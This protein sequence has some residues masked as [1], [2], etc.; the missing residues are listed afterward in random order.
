[1]DDLLHLL[2]SFIAS[3]P[4]LGIWRRYPDISEAEDDHTDSWACE[5]VSAEFA[6]FARDLG[7]DAAV[8]HGVD[9]EAPLAF[10]HA[11]VRLTRDGDVTDVDWTA[12]QYHNLF[13]P[14]GH[15]Q[16]VLDLP[17]PL[18]WDKGVVGINA[19]LIVGE[20]AAVTKEGQ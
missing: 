1:M 7:W 15:D 11:W 20:F 14:D 10:D 5:E 16:T 13:I 6:A 4:R 2:N 8:V 17:W 19:H 18:A 12:R 3:D 9:P